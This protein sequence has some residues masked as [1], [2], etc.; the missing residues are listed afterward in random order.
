MDKSSKALKQQMANKPLPNSKTI[1]PKQNIKIL[2]VE[3]NMIVRFSLLEMLK[4]LGYSA[5]FVEDGKAALAG[6]QS[7]YHLILMDIDIPYL[8]GLEVTQIIRAIEK[9]HQLRNV[10]IVAMTSHS[11]DPEYQK[12]CL[13]AGMDGFSGKLNAKQLKDLILKYAQRDHATD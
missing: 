3:D 7:D 13:S 11:D 5:D 2:I 12:K 4:Q 10:P 1:Q 6:Y 9:N 8:N